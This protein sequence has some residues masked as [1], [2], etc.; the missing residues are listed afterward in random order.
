MI[1]TAINSLPGK[2][3]GMSARSLYLVSDLGLARC[4]LDYSTNSVKSVNWRPAGPCN[5]AFNEFH[6]VR[7]GSAST[8]APAASSARMLAV[9]SSTSN[10]TRT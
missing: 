9:E 3:F 1:D 6:G 5:R 7:V 8:V 2:R 10:A 4:S